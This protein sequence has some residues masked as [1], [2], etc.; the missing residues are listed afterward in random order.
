MDREEGCRESGR[1]EIIRGFIKK[2]KQKY[3]GSDMQKQAGQM[4][5]AGVGP[6]QV[7]VQDY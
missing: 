3:N 1:P 2:E 5:T 4:M 7:P 6:E